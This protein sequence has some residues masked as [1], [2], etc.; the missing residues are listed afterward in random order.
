[1]VGKIIYSPLFIAELDDLAKVLYRQK[2]FSFLE[3][4]DIYID[5]IYDFIESNI[6]YPISKNSPESH[7][8]FGK[9][10]IKYKANNRTTWY[11]F[12]DQKEDQFIINHI[13]NNHSQDFPELL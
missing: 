12:F 10:F 4:V 5:K 3:D 9:N 6:E 13:L 1:M 2:Y 11:I 7:Q 8:K